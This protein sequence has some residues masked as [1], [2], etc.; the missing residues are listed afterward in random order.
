MLPESKMADAASHAR[1]CPFVGGAW[2]LN[3]FSSWFLDL[4]TKGKEAVISICKE[5]EH[6]VWGFGF[7]GPLH[8]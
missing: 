1:A 6:R 5:G 8:T 4:E 7:S 2:E 3:I